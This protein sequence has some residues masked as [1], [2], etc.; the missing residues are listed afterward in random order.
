MLEKLKR[1]LPP[2][3]T[4]KLFALNYDVEKCNSDHLLDMDGEMVRYEAADE[5][6]E[7]FLTRCN[8]LQILYL[9]I[10][11]PVILIVNL[12]SKLVNGLRGVVKKLN[13]DSVVV[14]FE[15]IQKEE[16]IFPYRFSVFCP[17]VQRDVASRQQM[18][19]KLAFALTVHKAQGMSLPKVV[20]DCRNMHNP[21]Q[22][23]VA[24]GRATHK[25]GLQ[26]INYS[27]HL[28][29]LHPEHISSFY[30]RPSEEP[31]E[32]LHCC[33]QS[34]PIDGS[35]CQVVIADTNE[36][37]TNDQNNNLIDNI[38]VNNTD[39]EENVIDSGSEGMVGESDKEY[40]ERDVNT[41]RIDFDHDHSGYCQ[42]MTVSFE[43]ISQAVNK[44]KYD[45]PVTDG[46]TK[47]NDNLNALLS[48]ADLTQ[49]FTESILYHFQSAFN[50]AM[51]RN[52]NVKVE[53]KHITSFYSRVTLFLQT[54]VYTK[55]VKKLYQ[56]EALNS[57]HYRA[58]FVIVRFAREEI[59]E[60]TSNPT[61]QEAIEEAKTIAGEIL[62]GSAA[63]RGKQR[64]IGGWVVAKLKHK[65]KKFVRKNLYKTSTKKAADKADKEVKILETLTESESTLLDSSHD[66]ESL[67][68]TKNKQ[69]LRGG[70]TNISD[71]AFHFFTYLDNRLQQLMTE[72]AVHIHGKNFHTYLCD[73]ISCDED[74]YSIFT[75][76]VKLEFSEDLIREVFEEA[77]QKFMMVVTAQ[78]RRDFLRKLKVVKEEAHRKEI[79]A[80]KSKKST[81]SKKVQDVSKETPMGE[82]DSM[83]SNIATSTKSL[84]RQMQQ[85][86]SKKRQRGESDAL[87]SK[88]QQKRNKKSR[89]N[90][91]ERILWP[92]G[93]CGSSCSDSC[94]CCDLCDK[95]H[96]YSCLNCTGDEFED[97]WFCPACR[98]SA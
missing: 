5:G 68:F 17:E 29:K 6:D 83:S 71:D 58:A 55:L 65:K 41:A 51:P 96:H 97:D 74:V 59:I 61:L 47:L 52:T 46:Q 98:S 10:G 77:V 89:E 8:G 86:I 73:S 14:N 22:I 19:L 60:R 26:I 87:H 28:L 79:K 67:V 39:M 7:K 64:Y 81:S 33:R 4:A 40:I 62:K 16:T 85:C 24:V 38:C 54:S 42:V 93:I 9:K 53:N 80:A 21:G 45:T 66:Q 44:E 95:W 15:S 23:G 37:S 12:S 84:Y 18:P 48:N 56:K 92:C 30:D 63:G 72:Q 13:K 57:I 82:S 27:D 3:P 90:H 70:L 11:A 2:G 25:D 91:P 36:I 50:M 94:V 76:A 20:I 49:D 32:D 34:V 35:N 31:A 75:E 88:K 43:K 1:P 78:F 69:N